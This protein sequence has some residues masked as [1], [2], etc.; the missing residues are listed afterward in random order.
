MS[1]TSKTGLISQPA[2]A[3][4]PGTPKGHFDTFET[5]FFEQG[6]DG[7]KQA[8]EVERFDDLDEAPRARS[9]APSRQLLLATVI[10]SASLAVLG[11]VALWRSGH[12]G[13]KTAVATVTPAEPVGTAAPAAPPEPAAAPAA[14][15]PVP[16]ADPVGAVPAPAP[17]VVPAAPSGPAV[18]AAATAAV[19]AAKPETEPAPAAPA[20]PAAKPEGE[21]DPVAAASNSV[22]MRDH[23]KQAIKEKRGK[24]ILSAC[25]EAFAADPSAAD[26]AV[27]VARVEFDRGRSA[28]AL[29]WGKKAVAAD[30]NAAD[31]YVFIGGAEQ[32]A[33]HGKA[34]KE[35]YRHYLQLAPG[36]RYAGDLRAIVGRL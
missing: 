5:K 31:A 23:C 22:S 21:P 36:G 24:D 14:M 12:V 9:F 3:A 32:N 1:S 6:D 13:T 27:A 2:T 15:A 19:P 25:A 28:Q 8:V 16:A 10:G 29:V 34:A 33:G 17:A 35:A 11:C 20:V 4:A 26:L 18:A 30:P 7:S